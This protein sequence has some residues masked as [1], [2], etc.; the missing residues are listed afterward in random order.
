[1]SSPRIPLGVQTPMEIDHKLMDLGG[2]SHDEIGQRR[3]NPAEGSETS[4]EDSDTIKYQLLDLKKPYRASKIPRQTKCPENPMNLLANIPTGC[5]YFTEDI[6]RFDDEPDYD[7]D[8]IDY[9]EKGGESTDEI[10][11]RLLKEHEAELTYK[12]MK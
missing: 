1:M 3:N 11:N 10:L 4:K 12:L 5:V 9:D 2:F 6:P 7:L 8:V